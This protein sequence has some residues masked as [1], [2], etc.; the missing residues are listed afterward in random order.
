MHQHGRS[1]LTFTSFGLITFDLRKL[2]L[3]GTAKG[4]NSFPT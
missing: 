3:L 2:P 1:L 4:L